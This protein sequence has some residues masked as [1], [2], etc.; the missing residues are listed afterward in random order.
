M[1]FRW[2]TQAVTNNQKMGVELTTET[3]CTLN[4][5]HTMDN[6]RHDIPVINQPLSDRYRMTGSV[7]YA[8]KKLNKCVQLDCES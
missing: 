1:T 6:T 2:L 3:S 8:Y 4:I 5:L 7:L